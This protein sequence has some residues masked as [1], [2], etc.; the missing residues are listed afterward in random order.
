MALEP[1]LLVADI[2]KIEAAHAAEPLM[3]R[4]GLA[5][6]TQARE[7]LDD[8]PPRVL[9]LAGPGNNGGDAFVVARWLKS[10]FFDV[11]VAFRGDAAKLSA[12]ALAAHWNWLSSGGT[13]KPEWTD[14]GDRGLI[15][16]GLFGIGL[17]RATD[18]VYANW[19]TR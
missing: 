15:V 16:D 9:V 10:W 18:G 13:L 14:S 1:I 7:L 4:A 3:E 19:I 11:S 6:A 2:R 12:D 17:K 8:R 5:A